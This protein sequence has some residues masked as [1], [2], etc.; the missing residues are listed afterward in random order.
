M[1][2][3]LIEIDDRSSWPPVDLTGIAQQLVNYTQEILNLPVQVINPS[4]KERMAA[5]SHGRVTQRC[6]ECGEM[7]F[8]EVEFGA[9]RSGYQRV[10]KACYQ[11]RLYPPELKELAI[12]RTTANLFSRYVSNLKVKHETI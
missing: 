1:R 7:K 12:E 5:I 3:L 11:A 10:C 6:V 2:Y 9:H 4:A 8:Q